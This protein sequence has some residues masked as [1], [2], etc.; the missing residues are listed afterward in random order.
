MV[1]NAQLAVVVSLVT[2]AAVATTLVVT[3]GTDDFAPP[4][5]AIRENTPSSF[6][7][8]LGEGASVSLTNSG[9]D[10][11]RLKAS[12]GGDVISFTINAGGA[13]CDFT[14]SKHSFGSGHLETNCHGGTANSNSQ[15]A[16]GQ[17]KANL[18]AWASSRSVDQ[19]LEDN[20]HHELVNNLADFLSQY[21]EGMTYPTSSQ[22]LNPTNDW[23]KSEEPQ[24][25]KEL[26]KKIDPLTG[27]EFDLEYHNG[28]PATWQG[29]GWCDSICNDA[30]HSWDGG[31][32]CAHT[33]TAGR[34]YPCGYVGYN[35]LASSSNPCTTYPT[36]RSNL[37][38]Q[39]SA[40]PYCPNHGSTGEGGQGSTCMCPWS[41]GGTRRAIYDGSW[42]LAYGNSGTLW[43][44]DRYFGGSASM[45][46]G[47]C[48][49][50]CNSADKESFI[51]CFDHDSCVDH[52]GGSAVSTDGDRCGDELGHA[53]DDYT[54]S[55]GWCCC[56]NCGWICG[57]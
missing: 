18:D 36:A 21:S 35:C 22:D 4:G 54:V 39:N 31:D 17:A 29:D 16:F 49:G 51:D 14:L 57:C 56:E 38:Y 27:K 43:Q 24:A 20:P 42:N 45:C 30:S 3:A 12:S 44:W 48:G 15:A 52:L 53:L 50:G 34:T 23:G 2:I 25:L 6:R 46:T 26:P 32:C 7:A 41:G 55:Y 47:R 28:C 13:S 40:E 19:R 5:M 1:N 37:F 33:C 10:A 9:G 8:D 11:R